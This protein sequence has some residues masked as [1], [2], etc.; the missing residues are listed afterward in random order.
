ME[1]AVF[2]VTKKPA[3]E[4]IPE[5]YLIDVK[6]EPAWRDSNTLDANTGVL[7]ITSMIM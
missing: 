6:G 7:D 2:N 3:V 4:V 5:P 1:G